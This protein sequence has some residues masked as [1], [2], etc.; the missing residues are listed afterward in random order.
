VEGSGATKRTAAS[1]SAVTAAWTFAVSALNGRRVS[2]A[3]ARL[4]CTPQPRGHA[5]DQEYR[6]DPQVLRDDL[7]PVLVGDDPA[8]VVVG[9]QQIVEL[10]Q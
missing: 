2:V 1:A 5:I 4:R 3:V 6:V 9:Q 7:T 10:R 8:A